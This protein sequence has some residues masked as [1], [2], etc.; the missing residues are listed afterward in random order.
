MYLKIYQLKRN[1]TKKCLAILAAT[2][3]SIDGVLTALLANGAKILLSR[4][5]QICPTDK[6]LW[7]ETI[8]K[9][10]I[11]LCKDINKYSLSFRDFH[12]IKPIQHHLFT[13][14]EQLKEVLI[15]SDKSHALCG[16]VIYFFIQENNGRVMRIVKAASK[17]FN[18]TVPTAEHVSRSIA[19][20]GVFTIL[21]VVYAHCSTLLIKFV[22]LSSVGQQRRT[23]Q[24]VCC[25]S[26]LLRGF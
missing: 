15:F 8:Y 18:S 9:F 7:S 3:M 11:S 25:W 16:Y 10:D 5:A 24:H 4:A 26:Q 12:P 13:Q 22:V 6:Q 17:T 2:I 23:E 19:L 21:Q 14:P 20:D 1:I